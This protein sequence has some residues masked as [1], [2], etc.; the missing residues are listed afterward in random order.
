MKKTVL[1]F[2]LIS[3]GVLS[4]I[5]AIMMPLCLN[6]TIP[7]ENMELMGYATMALAFF[8]VFFGIRSYREQ[9]NGGTITFGK[10]FKVGILIT[11]ITCAVYVIAWEIVYWGFIPDFGDKFAAITLEKLK[12]GGATPEAMTKAEAE[13]AR[14]KELY[15][16]PLFNVGIT[17]MEIFPVGLIVT[18]VSA[19]ILRR[20][21]P[22]ALATA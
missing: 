9:H 5:T 4:A 16:N 22:A 12:A 3:G 18:L 17:F 7:S 20:K 8:A 2:G 14:F 15:K 1:T 19:A 6:G 11:L 10:A 21:A 13:M